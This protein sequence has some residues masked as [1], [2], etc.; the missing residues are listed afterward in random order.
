MNLLDELFYQLNLRQVTYAT[1]D[2]YYRGQQAMSF[3]SPESQ[4]AIGNRLAHLVVNIPRV[5]VNSLAERCRI[6]GFTP[7]STIWDDFIAND[8]DQQA[9]IVHRTALLYGQS[10][11]IVWADADGKPTVSV[12]SPLNVEV[13]TDPAT[14]AITAAVKRWSDRI[15]GETHAMVYLP[16]RIEHWRAKTVRADS[17]GAF[18]LIETLPNALGVVPVVRFLNTD[19]VNDAGQWNTDFCGHGH[20]EIDG[21]MG[22]TDALCKVSSDMLIAS[23][24]LAKPRR[25]ATG[26]EPKEIPRLDND[27]NP[28]FENGEPV[29]DAVSP[30]PENDRFLLAEA[31]NA[32]F[33]QLSGSALDGY[34]NAADLILSE[35]AAVSSL[36]PHYLGIMH[37]NP[38][39][40]DALRASE[41]GLTSKAADKQSAFGRSWELVGKLMKAVRTGQRVTDIPCRVVWC[42]PG[43][44]SEAQMSDAVTKLVQAGIL[45]KSGALRR[46]GYTENEISAEAEARA[47][48]Q[49]NETPMGQFYG[50][51]IEST[52]R[53]IAA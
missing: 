10:F 22:L 16:D 37:D 51:Q 44:R 21:V 28:V 1:Y 3:I 45:S 53:Q 38:S 31:E 49:L 25:W 46:M 24:F 13:L 34:Q 5:L 33:G 36:P 47:S 14:R 48:E 50:R 43:T 30:F 19:L 32:K 42:D 15:N 39:S 17:P 41:A 11:V 7:D 23:E 18:V 35:I 8:L 27:G 9:G 12:E 29:L 4:K 52:A 26:V 40:A 2:R 6:L 20:S